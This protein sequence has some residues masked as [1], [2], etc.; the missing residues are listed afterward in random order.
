M[1][2]P[3]LMCFVWFTWAGGT[4]I[5]LELTG[6]AEGA[7]AGAS[8]GD[9][10]FAMTQLMIEPFGPFLSWAMAVI[11]VVLPMT[12]LVTSADSAVLIVNTINA[13]GDEGP[14]SRPHI[15]LWGTAPGLVVAALPLVAAFRRSR[16]PWSSERCPSRW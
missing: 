7:I 15:V 14:K 1:I 5:D 12:Y 4:A 3:S 16:P 9:K 11:I 8:D 13:A 6:T 2:V 10:I